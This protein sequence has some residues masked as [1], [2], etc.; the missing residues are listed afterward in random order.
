M[1][2][3]FMHLEMFMPTYDVSLGRSAGSERWREP[4]AF[5]ICS[6]FF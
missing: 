2:K 4:H 1:N 3:V 5:A 6:V